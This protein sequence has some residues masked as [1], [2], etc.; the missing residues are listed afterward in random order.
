MNCGSSLCCCGCVQDF[1]HFFLRP[2]WWIVT[3][4]YDTPLADVLLLN[5]RT[6]QGRAGVGR[7]K[8]H[9]DDFNCEQ[10]IFC[11]VICFASRAVHFYSTAAFVY[12][13]APFFIHPTRVVWGSSF[14]S[15]ASF[16]LFHYYVIKLPPSPPSPPTGR[17]QVENE[18]G[19]PSVRARP[20]FDGPPFGNRFREP[21]V[22]VRAPC[23][24]ISEP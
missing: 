22:Y 6:G 12:Y 7:N 14:L 10:M 2:N 8:A 20:T 19:R 9:D 18:M 1:S 15:S 4:R 5:A 16:H 21:N 24:K 23:A 3:W 17:Q 11:K 13:L